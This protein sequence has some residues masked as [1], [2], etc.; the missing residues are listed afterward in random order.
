MKSI[1]KLGKMTHL[2]IS[3]N[4]LTAMSVKWT[5]KDLKEIM[6]FDVRFN[7]VENIEKEGI[8]ALKSEN[9]QI[10]L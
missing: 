5:L 7:C 1:L 2:Y 8:R 10:F 3:S 4:K 9:L 6:V